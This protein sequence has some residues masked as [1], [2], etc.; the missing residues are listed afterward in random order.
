M[1]VDDKRLQKTDVI[2]VSDT[3]N[4]TRV[5]VALRRPRA[6]TF[7]VKMIFKT[8]FKHPGVVGI[9]CIFTRIPIAAKMSRNDLFQTFRLTVTVLPHSMDEYSILPAPSSATKEP[10]N[11][12]SNPLFSCKLPDLLT[13]LTVCTTLQVV[14]ASSSCHRC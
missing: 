13:L 2:D 1:N 10:D 3:D 4:L 6:S 5:D 11:C 7:G 8:R 14:T 9:C 12:G